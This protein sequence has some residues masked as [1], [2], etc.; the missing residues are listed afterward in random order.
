MKSFLQLFLILTLFF[1]SCKERKKEKK[2]VEV[3]NEI[4]HTVFICPME[5]E[6]GVTYYLEG[7]CDICHRNLVEKKKP[8]K[9]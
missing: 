2:K 8:K 7:K 1:I 9:P 6:T 3:A 5:C 4:N